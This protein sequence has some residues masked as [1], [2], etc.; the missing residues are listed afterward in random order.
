MRPTLPLALLL[1]C[2]C[3]KDP[4][5][6]PPK[7]DDTGPRDSAPDTDTGDP[8]AEGFTATTQVLDGSTGSVV[9]EFTA[10]ELGA[11]P[12]R[13]TVQAGETFETDQLADGPYGLRAWLDEDGDGAWDGIWA[14]QGEP[15]A[16]MGVTVPEAGLH[17]ALRRGV[18]SPFLDEAP[19]LVELYE[20]AWGF[21]L[22]HVAEGT[23]DNGF[24]DH[25]M[26]EAFCDLIFQW[27]SC[28]M[29]LFGVNGL[30]AF[31][32]MPTLDNF[33]GI[34]GDD[35]YICRIANESDGQAT[36]D[37][38]DP[39]EPMINPPL[40][41][42]AE[43]RYAQRS[44]DLSRLPRVLPVLE[45]YAGWLDANVRT[46]PGLYYTSMLGSGM[47]N[48]PR[49]SAYDGW[50]DQTAQVAL[51]RRN[52]GD[53]HTML[54]QHAQA[55][56]QYA[57][58][59]AVCEDV[60]SLMWDDQ[61]R[62]FFDLDNTG[63]FL[64]EKTLASVWPLV[65]E[66]A[67]AEQQAAVVAHLQD[68]SEFWRVHVFPSTAADAPSYDPFGYYWRGGV[69]APTTYASI[70]ALELAGRRDVALAAA[71]NHLRNLEQVYR[72]FEPDEDELAEE[73][74]GDG[75][76]TL[77][78]LY[79]PDHVRPG[80]RWDASLLGRQDFVGWTG[81]GPIALL[82]EQLIGLE[83]DATQ[84]RLTLHLNRSDRHGVEGY[85][86][87]DQLVD[88]EVAARA[89]AS[90][91]ATVTV[92]TTDAMTLRVEAAGRWFEFE[93]DPGE[94]RLEVDPSDSALA[95]ATVPGGPFPG[96]AVLGN[97]AVA[98]VYSDDDGSG[99]PPGIFHL[100]RGDFATD[101]LELGQT[102]VGQ[103]GVRITER[104]VGLDPFF[105]AYTE[106]PLPDGGVLAWRAFAGE[107]DAV[108]VQGSLV[109][110]AGSSTSVT[111]APLIQLREQV[112]MDGGLSWTELGRDDHRGSLWAELS[113]G[114]G[115]ALGSS[116]SVPDWQVGAVTADP[117]AGGL[118]NSIGEGRQLV[119]SWSVEAEAGLQVP[120]RWVLA[121]GEDPTEAIA[122]AEALIA[123]PDPL[124]DAG[125]HW[126]DW[127]PDRLC[128]G[129]RCESAAAN[130]YA[131][132][133]SSL[134]GAV[135]ADLTGQF[136]TNDRPQLY[137]RDALMVARVFEH[138]G[139]DEEAWEIV[140]FWLDPDLEQLEDGWWY[141]RYDA[142][143]RAVDGGSGALYDVPEWDCNGYLASLV[144]RLGPEELNADERAELLDGLDFLVATQDD[145]GLWS[146][147]GII[148]WV[149]RLPATTMS[150][151]DGL[152]AGARIADG[153][154]DPE[155]AEAYRAAAG[156]LR[157]GM[158]E[159]VVEDGAYLADEREDGLHY[160]TSLMFGPAWGYPADPLLDST[161]SWIMDH[162]RTHGGGVRYF[163]GLGYGQD[164]FGFTT[165]ATAQYAATIGEAA[166]AGEL[167][168]W[169]AAFS[170]R[171]GLFPERVYSDGS[172]AAE[173][174]PLSWCAAETAMGIL[175]LEAVEAL[176]MLPVVDGQLDPAE[177]RHLGAAA[178]DHDGD[179][180]E[181]DDMVAVYALRD[182]ADL[183]V[184]LQLA[185]PA[186]QAPTDTRWQLWLAGPE[187][188]GAESETEGGSPLRF[189]ADPDSVPGADAVIELSADG[190]SACAERAV[191][192]EVLEARI[193]LSPFGFDDAPIQLIAV[194]SA[195]RGEAL[196][197][198]HGSLL[199]DGDD[200]TVYVTFEV[201]A[202]SVLDQL[203]ADTTVTLSGD[204]AALGAWVG[205]AVE[206]YDDG[207]GMDLVAGDGIYTV[208]VATEAG[209][210]VAYKYLLGHPSDPSWEGVE[211]SGDDRALW[212]HDLDA[213]GRMRVLDRFGEPGGL[214]LDP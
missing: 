208:T 27:D 205:H 77:W 11:E 30:D 52:M 70:Q 181:I 41:A 143:G 190:C 175:R 5:D 20:A 157:A 1:L 140:R 42:W 81:L 93:L 90:A 170:N 3:P 111:V 82:L 22:E 185:G 94:H 87:G 164:L 64:G 125:E 89:D 61:E 97:G 55:E 76:N 45:A 13:F 103:D 24:A 186:N 113:D 150:N 163:E 151:W 112:H 139:R 120:F 202:A 69:W 108:I 180:D 66:C 19:E 133:A 206:L 183:F 8:P 118:D 85:R 54:G 9:L 167:L 31:P 144:D 117:V 128:A 48:A 56:A 74:R 18:P 166:A 213:S 126:Q 174:S 102:L 26:D 171:Y 178:L 132:R 59:D 2:G 33:Y 92:H 95:A 51:A 152:D 176:A 189:R 62:W 121:L 210:S 116:A 65:A 184:A 44:G 16:L 130:L 12:Q 36:G 4:S 67:T 177:Y 145:D 17:I 192:G 25:Y 46:G 122:R 15:T 195:A 129:A 165:S 38:S 7:T 72:G 86:F 63:A 104:S 197:P 212:V 21:A 156:H 147:G 106:V 34:Q 204:R 107:H 96:Y 136:V 14:G 10:V 79:A 162:A 100:Y 214:T 131:A 127:A 98:A 155:R 169:M 137:P 200:G 198:A 28:F 109:A 53:L 39:S 161:W 91:P 173:A 99:D 105:A 211:F 71:E 88:L 60:R 201:D 142:L 172:G 73:A 101:L 159:L 32:V 160:D 168:D 209:G 135:P 149:G 114:S 179:A 50:V 158:L 43:L 123:E 154:G 188:E 40:F 37:A 207:A 57:A 193:D 29:V 199:S 124:A 83:P 182:G 119:M 196:L 110:P 68:P 148:E 153:W 78:E 35:G 84:D 75:T 194:R 138:V 134:G 49:D 146:E 23:A 47:D 191:E 141:A 6:S 203:D 80:T 187:G 58:A 115:L